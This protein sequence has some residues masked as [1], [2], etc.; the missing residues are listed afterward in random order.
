MSRHI[1]SISMALLKEINED[2]YDLHISVKT[3]S[4]S[5]AELQA[6]TLE[7]FKDGKKEVDQHFVD[8]LEL[9]KKE[10]ES[11]V[12]EEINKQIEKIKVEVTTVEPKEKV[13]ISPVTIILV[14]LFF[15][16]SSFLTFALGRSFEQNRYEQIIKIIPYVELDQ[17][18]IESE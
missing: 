9:T 10:L 14:V 8:L 11:E 2:I 15:L 12:T 13:R 3:M 4:K 18:T 5:V 16:G 7:I 6:T 1:D 17:L